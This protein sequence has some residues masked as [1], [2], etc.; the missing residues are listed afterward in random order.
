MR[1]FR[2][3]TYVIFSILGYLIYLGLAGLG[4]V[5]VYRPVGLVLAVLLVAGVI[6]MWLSM[7]LQRRKKS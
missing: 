3:L 1:P 4:W 5:P 7:W 2:G 6:H